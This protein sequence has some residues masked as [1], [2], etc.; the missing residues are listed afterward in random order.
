MKNSS[1]PVLP[2]DTSV[3]VNC[4]FDPSYQPLFV[5]LIF[6]IRDCQFQPRCALEVSD[7]GEVRIKKI[8]RI[9]AECRLGIHDIS[10][11]E[12]SL[13]NG[14]PRFNMPLELGLFLGAR[15]FGNRLQKR[16][17]C[18]IL[19]SEPY[20]YREFCSDISGQDIE[21]HSSEASRLVSKTRNW[22]QGIL[23]ADTSSRVD[24]QA[25]NPLIPGG[26]R[27]FDRYQ[28]FQRELPETCKELKLDAAPLPF[29]EFLY[30]VD[31]WLLVNNWKPG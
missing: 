6:T 25:R 19:D 16:K 20:R 31:E 23:A 10:R 17:K 22:L 26:Q 2:Y 1:P 9:I 12:M 14:L 7:S 21:D 15:S 27:I 4:P 8:E 13:A 30:L 11:I 29:V 3:F 5:A 18:L 24:K 28:H